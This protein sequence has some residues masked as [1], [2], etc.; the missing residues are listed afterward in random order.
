MLENTR[1]TSW[2]ETITRST[3]PRFTLNSVTSSNSS[4][5]SKER[6]ELL[7][8]LFN[9]VPHSSSSQSAPSDSPANVA[10]RGNTQA[11]HASSNNSSWIVDSGASD[12]MTG[13]KSLFTSYSPCKCDMTVT[14]ADGTQ[15]KVLGIGIVRISQQLQLQDVLYVPQLQCNLLSV[16]RLNKDSKC[17][18]IFNTSSCLFQVQGSKVI[19]GCG[20]Q[21]GGLYILK[22]E[23]PT[24][25]TLP[26]FTIHSGN[27]SRQY[28]AS[29]PFSMVHCDIWGPSWVTGLGGKKWFLL[30][31]DD[32]GQLSWVFLMK[33]KGKLVHLSSNSMPWFVHSFTL[34]HRFSTPTTPASS[35]TLNT[36]HFSP[37]RE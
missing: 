2:L 6:M 5:F 24:P 14:I 29:R 31:V 13:N 19:I 9:K 12:H 10:Q 34:S 18:T 1:Q 3:R 33:E 25:S 23:Q 8:S 28:T 15:S 22:S 30:L 37:T 35:L 4:L 27:K 7:Y 32:H 17:L 21:Q 16:R 20:E 26:H 11:Y 36:A